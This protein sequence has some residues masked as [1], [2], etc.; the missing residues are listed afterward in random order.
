MV[1]PETY[2]PVPDAYCLD[3]GRVVPVYRWAAHEVD[4]VYVSPN[5]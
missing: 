3:A 4:I 5:G 1:G 2:E